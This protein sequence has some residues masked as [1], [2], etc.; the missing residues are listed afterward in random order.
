MLYP[1]AP[2]YCV[3]NAAGHPSGG[4]SHVVRAPS[5]PIK[6]APGARTPR[7]AAH[8]CGLRGGGVLRGG[9][10]PAAS[11]PCCEG[12]GAA[13]HTP[14]ELGVGS[15]SDGSPPYP[16]REIPKWAGES[17][18]AHT[19]DGPWRPPTQT[20]PDSDP[21]MSSRGPTLAEGVYEVR[22]P[23]ATSDSVGEDTPT[24]T[25]GVGDTP[26]SSTGSPS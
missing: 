10:L 24:G 7:P 14:H 25:W 8:A 6:R 20:L 26:P 23:V 21:G 15:K 19:S 16:P 11:P 18:V 22:K 9:Y 1:V 5:T 2:R 3:A 17:T 4:V 13:S 12:N